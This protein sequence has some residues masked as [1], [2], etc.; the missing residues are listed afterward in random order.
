MEKKKLS[1]AWIA[2]IVC[3]CL[4]FGCCIFGGIAVWLSGNKTKDTTTTTKTTTITSKAGETTKQPAAVATETAAETTAE[5]TIAAPDIVITAKDLVKA[6][7]DNEV[8]ADKLYKNK[9]AEIT[10]TIYD[11]SVVLGVTSVTLS[12]DDDS[13]WTTVNCAFKDKNE[14][15]KIA[16]M[17]KGDT[18]TI[19]GT[20]KGSTL[21]ISIEV[22][23]CSF[24]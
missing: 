19:L 16:D 11:I 22:S 13:I 20:I 3:A 10:G 17:S 9:S 1:G 24:K 15:D 5:T 8:A 14:I 12:S 18:V 21:G 7:D 2:I 6:Y 23:D 4:L